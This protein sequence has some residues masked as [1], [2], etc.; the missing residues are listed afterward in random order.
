MLT[1]IAFLLPLLRDSSE[2]VC[3][4]QAFLLNF[5]VLASFIYSSI[6]L[7][8]LKW[9][10]VHEKQQT[11]KLEAFYSLLGWGLP[12]VLSCIPFF[13]DSYKS[14]GNWCWIPMNGTLN[15]MLQVLEGY[16]IA[17]VVICFNVFCLLA[18]SKKLKSEIL[19]DAEG[20][21][22]RK[23]LMKRMVYYPFVIVVCIIPA[24]VNRAMMMAGK[25]SIVMQGLAANVQCLM[26]FGNCVI[27]GFTD[28]LKRKLK[29]RFMT[30]AD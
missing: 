21:N 26:G 19:L 18:I 11:R 9:C 1:S 12:M 22:M 16:G 23:R 15:K 24:A 27:Y 6:I 3:K 7:H 2:E 25:D 29:K 8:Y 30:L 5:G 14:S 4:A 20:E 17:V 28:N 13:T 10:I